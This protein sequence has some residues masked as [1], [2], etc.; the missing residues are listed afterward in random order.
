MKDKEKE[1]IIKTLVMSGGG[2]KGIAHIGVLHALHEL[3]MLDNIETFAGASVGSLIM[4]LYLIGYSPLELLEFIKKFNLESMKNINVLGLFQ[5]KGLDNGLKIEYVIQELIY[6]KCKNKSITLQEVYEKTKKK[7]IITTVC[8]NTMSACYMS[9]ETHPEMPLFLAIRMSIGIPLFYSPVKY[10]RYSYIDGGCIDN[11][12]I[13]LFHDSLDN[14]LGIYL[15]ESPNVIENIDD[16]ETYLF[17]IFQCFM[18][19]VNFNSKKG[20][21][22]HTINIH[23]ESVSAVNYNIDEK[24]K[25]EIFNKGYTTVK[26]FY[27]KEKEKEK[28]DSTTN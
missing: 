5:N 12:P 15:I 26:E 21:E 16:S 23:L 19:G 1:N 25:T 18:E 6:A 4:S 7:L 22:K 8:V 14:T 2:I 24:K 13:H 3:K 27:Q 20:Y 10:D 28:I 17:R 11:Y 9:H